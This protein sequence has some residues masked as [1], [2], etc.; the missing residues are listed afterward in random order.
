MALKLPKKVLLK[1]AAFRIKEP[2]Y[3]NFLAG[4]RAKLRPHSKDKL[5]GDFKIV[6]KKR[7]EPNND[8][9]K[10]ENLCTG[11]AVKWLLVDENP[12]VKI[13]S[14][15]YINILSSLWVHFSLIGFLMF[16]CC[17]GI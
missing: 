6:Q 1:N 3:L 2:H 14:T 8:N 17:M 4:H 15:F 13:E 9:K 7:P 16:V 10:T 5:A 12:A 11:L